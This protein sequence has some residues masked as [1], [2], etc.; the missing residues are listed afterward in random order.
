MWVTRTFS[1]K[2]STAPPGNSPARLL[3]PATVDSPAP[4]GARCSASSGR[5]GDVEA[6]KWFC[7][8]VVLWEGAR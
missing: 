2:P 4:S 7:P 1:A 5:T 8:H 3:R 6:A